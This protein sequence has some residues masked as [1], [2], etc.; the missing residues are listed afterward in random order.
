MNENSLNIRDRFQ[1]IV[2]L[3]N[4]HKNEINNISI[5][6]LED[7]ISR[8]K[9]ILNNLRQDDECMI[10]LIKD[11]KNNISFGESKK[12][13]YKKSLFISGSLGVVNTFGVLVTSKFLYG[14]N[15]I[16]NVLAGIMNT[17][18]IFTINSIINE[19][20]S[21]LDNAINERKK[22]QIDIV[23]LVKLLKEIKNT[24]KLR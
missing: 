5:N 24:P 13:N 4:N 1:K 7:D 8:I 12:K 10:I 19:L 9:T 23:N 3:F 16:I 18:D 14:V 22:I 17:K 6:N 21:F 2:E 20:N 11:I 15:F